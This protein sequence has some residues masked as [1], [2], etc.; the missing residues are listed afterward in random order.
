MK[1]WKRWFVAERNMHYSQCWWDL[2]WQRA[3]DEPTSNYPP[4][5]AI[6]MVLRSPLSF[7]S[8]SSFP[9]PSQW[10]KRSQF[11]W[12]ERFVF[13][14]NPHSC[15]NTEGVTKSKCKQK[16]G[17]NVF[18]LLLVF[19]NAISLRETCKK[20]HWETKRRRRRGRNIQRESFHSI[21]FNGIQALDRELVQG[22]L[23][24][25]ALLHLLG[26]FFSLES[27]TTL[28]QSDP[29]RKCGIETQ[30]CL[31]SKPNSIIK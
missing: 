31:K 24:F 25:H 12:S 4:C 2:W 27:S 8:A 23:Q 28:L 19:W 22:E 18:W 15:N 17:F 29:P 26:I 13:H 21:F 9:R 1:S 11:A 16:L 20:R 30:S 14:R 7:S 5:L 10:P 6:A 3:P